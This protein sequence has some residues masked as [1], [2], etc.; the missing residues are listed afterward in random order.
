MTTIEGN[1][2]RISEV[3]SIL[4]SF[5]MKET[6]PCVIDWNL[7]MQV[8]ERIESLDWNVNING[9]DCGYY[10]NNFKSMAE[11]VSKSFIGG[12]KLFAVCSAVIDFIKRYNKQDY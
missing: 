12:T 3:D 9:N 1:K 10:D 7:L 4:I 8:V 6:Y 2:I 11:G 5:F